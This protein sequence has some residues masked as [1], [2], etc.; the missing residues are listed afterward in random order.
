MKNILHDLRDFFFPRMC[1]CCGKILSAGE[2]G[3]C[4]DCLCGLPHTKLYNTP[5]NEM[6]KC[7]WGCFPI[8]RASSLYYYS[9]GS[10]VADILHG[11]KYFGRKKLC[12]QM[13]RYIA[14]ELKPFGFFDGI[15]F[16]IPVPLHKKRYRQR[17]YNQSRLLAD[18]ISEKTSIPVIEN[19]LYRSHNNTTQTHKSAY[20]RWHNTL[21]LFVAGPLSDR[22]KG[23]H[24]LLVDDV[25]TT[26]ATL[27]SCIDSL[28]EITDIKI[29]VVTLAWAK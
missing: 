18:G 5:G 8:E 9:K 25:L 3:L 24:I 16:I 26:G 23:K 1:I 17:G 7:F 22:L 13:G 29:S 14:S 4:I 19:V 12:R 20:E 6:D 2:E 15:D 11:M 21:G 27:T 10:K 28:K